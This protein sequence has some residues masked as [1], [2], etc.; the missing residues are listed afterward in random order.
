MEDFLC[1]HALDGL[2]VLVSLE[3]ELVDLEAELVDLEVELVDAH[4][5][6]KSSLG[7]HREELL[8][9]DELVGLGWLRLDLNLE[10]LVAPQVVELLVVV[11][12]NVV[13]RRL[14]HLDV[15]VHAPLVL[16]AIGVA[17]LVLA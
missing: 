13:P 9:V 2:D 6:G 11:V 12:I 16:V 15:V 7:L 4:V 10:G 3:K 8:V 1:L 17:V 14:V 5:P